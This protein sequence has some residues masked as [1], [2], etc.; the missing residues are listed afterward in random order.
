M[1]GRMRN[2]RVSGVCAVASSC[3]AV[4]ARVYKTNC[5]HVNPFCCLKKGR[6]VGL[7]AVQHGSVRATQLHASKLRVVLGPMST[8]PVSMCVYVCVC[9]RVCVLQ[10]LHHC[11][12]R[13][14]HAGPVWCRV[15]VRGPLER[16]TNHLQPPVPATNG[17]P[18]QLHICCV[19]DCDS[20]HASAGTVVRAIFTYL[21]APM[22]GA[23][24]SDL[25]GYGRTGS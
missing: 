5:G 17:Q 1:C 4:H 22:R 15:C 18:C 24:H 25:H 16:H 21:V 12:H 3:H 6:K 20:Q 11:L 9:V 7:H 10:V 2:S 23:Y 14:G 8:G 13:P 19:C